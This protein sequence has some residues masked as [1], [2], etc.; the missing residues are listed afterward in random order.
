M[1]S[2][3]DTGF[4]RRARAV[5]LAIV[6]VFALLAGRIFV[7]QTY[8]YEKYRSKVIS[9]L[10][11]VSPSVAERGE[12]YDRSGRLLASNKTTYRVFISPSAISSAQKALDGRKTNSIS[13]LIA[14][15]LSQILGVD[16]ETIF[17]KTQKTRRLDETVIRNA[18]EDTASKIRSLIIEERLEHLVFLEASSSR[19]YPYGSLASHV[20]GFTG[21]DGDGLYGLEYQ[22]N[23]KIRGSNGYYV[24]AR[25]SGGHELPKFYLQE[26]AHI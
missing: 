13:Q 17:K 3:V 5:A 19:Y 15:R 9:Q 21:A 1:V 22:Y 10:T 24:T 26:R 2:K 18:D 16:S 23:E 6:V 14:D 8:G 12:I 25:D 4:A 11:T 20:I 7:Y